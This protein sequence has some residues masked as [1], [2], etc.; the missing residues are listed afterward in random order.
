MQRGE[1]F[2]VARCSKERDVSYFTFALKIVAS[3]Y[4]LLS[5]IASCK[6]IYKYDLYC[7]YFSILISSSVL[8]HFS[9]TPTV[10]IDLIFSANIHDSL[11]YLVIKI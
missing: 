11:I 2:I 10:Q 5:H 3:L 8:L 7:I 4:L 6:K 9:I 1:Y